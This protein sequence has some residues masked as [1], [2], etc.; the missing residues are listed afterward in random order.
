VRIK[1]HSLD[2]RLGILG[3]DQD[4]R[5]QGIPD[6]AHRDPNDVADGCY[7]PHCGGCCLMV[8]AFILRGI[9]FILYL[10]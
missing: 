10:L 4:V 6:I 9:A 8:V 5:A 7:R 3:G 1:A 2:E